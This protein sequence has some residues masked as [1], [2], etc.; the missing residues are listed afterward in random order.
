[1]GHILPFVEHA[2]GSQALLGQSLAN[3]SSIPVY[4]SK[5]NPLQKTFTLISS[6]G[7]DVMSNRSSPTIPLHA[8]RIKFADCFR[9]VLAAGEREPLCSGLNYLLVYR[10][11]MNEF[12]W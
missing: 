7:F 11:S 2:T 5:N 8:D 1:V 4:G 6:L 9:K 12:N 3:I 10:C